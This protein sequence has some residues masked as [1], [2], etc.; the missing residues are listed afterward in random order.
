[1]LQV[2]HIMLHFSQDHSRQADAEL[3]QRLS[4]FDTLS[5]SPGQFIEFRV[6]DSCLGLDGSLFH[7]SSGSL[8]S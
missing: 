4:P 1:M 2:N 6:H 3:L 8:S 7:Q 5:Q